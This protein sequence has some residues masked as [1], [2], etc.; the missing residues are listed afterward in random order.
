M[1][2]VFFT[3]FFVLFTSA[4]G[5]TQTIVLHEGTELIRPEQIEV[6]L[7]ANGEANFQDILSNASFENIDADIPFP[8]G[9]DIHWVHFKIQNDFNFDNDW[10]FDFQNWSYVDFY[11]SRGSNDYELKKTGHL[12]PYR[13]R[14]YAEG[15][16]SVLTIHLK[17]N[18]DIDCYV[19]L[20][21]QFNNFVDPLNFQFTLSPRSEFDSKV[22]NSTKISYIFIGICLVM[23]LYNFFIFISTRDRAYG[24]YL[25][26]LTVL[27]LEISD[28]SGILLG[29]FPNFDALPQILNFW[30]PIE[31]H[32]T[33]IALLFYVHAF[34]RVKER[35]PF[36]HKVFMFMVYFV[37]VLAA[38]ILIN[39]ELGEK[40]A[41]LAAV[42]F[43]FMVFTVGI[44]SLR[45]KYPGSIYF[46][47]GHTFWFIGGVTKMIGQVF[48]TQAHGDFFTHHAMALGSSIEMVLFSLALANT[49]NHL[50]KENE[51]KQAKIISQL[52]V[53]AELQTKVTRELEDKVAERTV[54]I[55][56]QKEEIAAQALNLE[57]EKDR[58]ERLLLNIL[59]QEV[60]EE[61]KKTGHAT[62]R[63]Y[64][65]VTIIF[66][67]IIEFSKMVRNMSPTAIVQDLDYIFS[68]FDT[69]AEKHNLEKIKTIGDAYMAV[70]GLP[71]E[72]TS[73]ASDTVSAGLEMLDFISAWINENHALGKTGINLRIGVNTGSVTSGVVGKSKF[74]FDIW[75]D[76][77][78]LASRMETAG[79]PGRVNISKYTY[80]EIKDE[81]HCMH[82]GAFPIKNMGEVDMYHIESKK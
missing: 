61:L 11:F 73:H 18:Q 20:N 26:T 8:S 14:D 23:L 41:V 68:A 75:G 51:Q 29:L 24:F 56:K 67:D 74:Q 15:A 27:I 31:P 25:I 44:K 77:V 70:G 22:H 76:A 35:Y 34:L 53:N 60:A 40:L 69:I 39:F 81:F 65:S 55:T 63:F 46:I 2:S 32:L 1:K 62:P 48:P 9:R 13:E 21:P 33:T 43:I 80:E 49:I 72:N 79:E 5:N 71:V 7:D 17:A 57:V 38:I 82:R 58:S 3:L 36:W 30:N 12:L 42:P 54:E 66:V 10:V 37:I 4:L 6:Y 50:R 16:R 47:I 52:Q 59:P 64:E 45:A 19:R 28:N 78:N